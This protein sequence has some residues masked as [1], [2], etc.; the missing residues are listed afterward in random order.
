[1]L[2]QCTNHSISGVSPLAQVAPQTCELI[3]TRPEI[4]DC[5]FMNVNYVPCPPKCQESVMA[6]FRNDMDTN[7]DIQTLPA[8]WLLLLY[9]PS[10]APSP[11]HIVFSWLSVLFHVTQVRLNPGTHLKPHFGNGP[12]LSAHL[13]VKA[14][15]PLK[16]G[17]TVTWMHRVKHGKVVLNW[18]GLNIDSGHLSLAWEVN[19]GFPGLLS[20]GRSQFDWLWGIKEFEVEMWKYHKASLEGD[21]ELGLSMKDGT[22]VADRKLLWVEGEAIL[23]DDTYPHMVSH[24]GEQPRYVILVWF[25]HPCDGGNPHNQTCPTLW[26]DHG[27]DGIMMKPWPS[28]LKGFG[29]LA[30]FLLLPRFLSSV[31]PTK[32]RCLGTWMKI[33]QGPRGQCPQRE[34][35]RDQ[36]K[37]GKM[38][39]SNAQCCGKGAPVGTLSHRNR[40]AQQ[41]SSVEPVHCGMEDF[42]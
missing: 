2:V 26:L 13:S 20:S 36:N 5:K 33:Y 35:L 3:K 1:M 10:P 41:H 7:I 32:N 6:R 12:R 18:I 8:I 31:V 42:K 30:Q 19:I 40:E 22:K 17:M 24:W 29:C 9:F 37:D 11:F 39:S 34:G 15:E 38:Q 21:V 28:C 25:C 23:F 4:N 27:A 14:P 16:A